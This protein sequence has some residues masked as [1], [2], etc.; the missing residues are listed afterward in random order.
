MLAWFLY[1]K[2]FEEKISFSMEFKVSDFQDEVFYTG[3]Q[4]LYQLWKK[5]TVLL[6]VPNVEPV[7]NA[8]ENIGLHKVRI[9]Q[10]AINEDL[11]HWI[12][13]GIFYDES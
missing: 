6:S 3:M 13:L 5:I 1:K 9:Q 8:Y 7:K 2:I 10:Y 12:L 11:C 4:A